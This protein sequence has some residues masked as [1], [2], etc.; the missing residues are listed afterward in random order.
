M[1]PFRIAPFRV[2]YV[3]GVMP[4]KWE[5]VWA[6]RRRRPLELVRLEVAGQ[7]QAVRDGEVDMA[8]VRG[9]VDRD[10]MHL[11]PLYREVPVVVVPA[12]HP[13]SAYDE[14][15]VTDLAGELDVLAEFPDITVRQAVETVAA[16]TGIA[17][18]PMSLARLHHRKDVVHRPVTGVEESPVGLAWL[19]EPQDRE[20]DEDVQAFI[21]VV[22]GRTPRSSRG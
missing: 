2:G 9:E 21:G 6:E 4:G 17:I 11:I 8:L 3:P 15:D 19:R 13:V 20:D 12:D 22:R 7:E 14:I 10:L 16:G 1:E 5:R 18:V